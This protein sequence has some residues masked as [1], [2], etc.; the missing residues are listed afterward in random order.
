MYKFTGFTDNANNALNFAVEAAEDMGHTYIGSE[1]VLFGLL[2]D[3]SNTAAT[4]LSAYKITKQKVDELL[5]QNIGIGIPTT[6]SPD[7]FTPR[8]K[9]IIETALIMG[10]SSRFGSAG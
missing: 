3:A 1:H 10:K 4:A 2:V 8:C 9:H 5:K 6:L 7:D